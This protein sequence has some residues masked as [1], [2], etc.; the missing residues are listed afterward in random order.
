VDPIRPIGPPDRTVQPVELRR[1]TPLEREEEKE[2][3]E[4][5]RKRREK[6]RTRREGGEDG[7][8]GGLDVR[9]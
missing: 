6:A 1:L 8:S 7:P 9:V 5:A 2:R 4:Q 3:R